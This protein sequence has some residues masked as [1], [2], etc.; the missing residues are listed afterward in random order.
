MKPKGYGI[1]SPFIHFLALVSGVTVAEDT[2]AVAKAMCSATHSPLAKVMMGN[3]DLAHQLR[4]N[5]PSDSCTTLKDPELVGKFTETTYK[6]DVASIEYVTVKECA[7]NCDISKKLQ[8]YFD[9]QY[10]LIGSVEEEVH[11][12]FIEKNDE[13][14]HRLDRNCNE[15]TSQGKEIKET[16]LN[17]PEE[18]RESVEAGSLLEYLLQRCR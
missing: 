17:L 14:A 16:I 4:G 6:R 12:A 7:E 2:S 9:G 8:T 5:C 13:A 18:T 15:D 11:R 10:N 3:Q 1:A